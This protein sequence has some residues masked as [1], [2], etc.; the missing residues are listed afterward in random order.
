MSVVIIGT[1][2]HARVVLDAARSWFPEDIIGALDDDPTRIGLSWQGLPVG[3]PIT[4]DAV[5]R[6][7]ADSAV[8]AI[9]NNRDRATLADRLDATVRWE[10]VRH[11][12]AIV[13]CDAEIGAGSVVMAGA[14]IQPGAVLGKHT[15]VNT[16]ASV[17]HDCRIG[18]FVHIAPGVRLCGNVTVGDG[19]L[20]GVGAVAIPGVRIGS[21]ATVGAGATVVRDVPDGAT[22]LGVPA[23]QA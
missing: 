6:T 16:G 10:V 1:G 5:A 2:G 15:I 20:I 7:G 12:S 22:V 21:W 8:L 17:D 4:S 23:R 3:G 9:G 14:I 11:A 18:D 13:S 19:S